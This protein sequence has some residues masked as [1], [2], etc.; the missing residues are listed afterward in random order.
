M[1]CFRLFKF[2]LESAHDSIHHHIAI[3]L[4]VQSAA[5]LLVFYLQLLTIL[6]A[7]CIIVA[8]TTLELAQLMRV[9]SENFLGLCLLEL[10]LLKL[11]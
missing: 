6:I 11:G 1:L 5:E 7:L 10:F 8:H 9:R 4:Y 2:L 3:L